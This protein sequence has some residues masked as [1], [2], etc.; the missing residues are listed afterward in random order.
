MNNHAN[1]NYRS[2]PNVPRHTALIKISV[3]ITLIVTE[4]CVNIH[5]S[6]TKKKK[7]STEYGNTGVNLTTG[8]SFWLGKT[9]IHLS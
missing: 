7:R 5:I 9:G 1:E 2:M 6:L 4:S 8:G 3:W